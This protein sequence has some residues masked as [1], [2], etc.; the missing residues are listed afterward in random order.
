M[1]IVPFVDGDLA[2]DD[3]RSAAIALFEDFEEVMA[4][5][6]IERFEARIVEDEQLHTAERAQQ[7]DVA[8]IAAGEREVGE[9]LGA[10]L[11][12]DGA[13]VATGF[14]VKRAQEPGTAPALEAQAIANPA[15]ER[16]CPRAIYD[17]GS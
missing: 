16:N 11:V 4:C 6:G 12:K 14:V 2:G 7:A 10:A 3:C 1:S 13:I 5:G 8:A 17:A 9:E 15:L